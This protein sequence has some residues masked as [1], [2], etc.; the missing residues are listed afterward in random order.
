MRLAKPCPAPLT[1]P[2][3]RRHTGLINGR[4]SLTE[5]RP[6]PALLF[7]RRHDFPRRFEGLNQIQEIHPGHASTRA[8]S[9]VPMQGP[10]MT[11]AI[12]QLL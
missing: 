6:F 4:N 8:V 12:F 1:L 5:D 3:G 9:V 7:T 2:R 11:Y 10:A